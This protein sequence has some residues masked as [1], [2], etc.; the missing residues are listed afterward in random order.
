MARSTGASTLHGVMEAPERSAEWVIP[1]DLARVQPLVFEAAS[2][3]ETHGVVGK[4]LFAAQLVLEEVVVN[5][6]Q[7][8]FDGDPSKEIRI[9]LSVDADAVTLTVEDEGRPFDPL[10]QAPNADTDS[11]IGERPLGGM[12]LHL[13]REFASRVD[14][15]RVGDT[16]RVSMRLASAD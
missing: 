7:H 9:S 6:V 16:N 5:V 4:P 13:V 3:L 8:A 14:Y 15:A 1:A 12:G 11:P 10:T 2:F